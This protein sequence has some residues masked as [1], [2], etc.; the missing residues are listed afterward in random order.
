MVRFIRWKA[1]PTRV[2]QSSGSSLSAIEV[3]PAMSAN[4]TVIG[5][6]SLTPAPGARSSEAG[7]VIPGEMLRPT[8]AN[9]TSRVTPGF[10]SSPALDRLPSKEAGIAIFLVQP[11]AHIEEIDAREAHQRK[12]SGRP[13]AVL[14]LIMAV[15]SAKTGRKG[16]G[17][18]GIEPTQD[19]STAPRKRF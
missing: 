13:S 7:L 12:R 14:A 11:P 17:W 3:D 18:M 8:C 15:N 6:R 9:S 2:V 1:S 5:R 19:A 16:R 4:R 10:R